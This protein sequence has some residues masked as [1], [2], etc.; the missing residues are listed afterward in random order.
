M[1]R[2]SIYLNFERNAEEAFNF[3][4]TVFGTEFLFPI[5]RFGSVPPMDGQLPVSQEDQNLVMNVQLPI[6]GGAILM[7]NDAPQSMGYKIN[8]GN[9]VLINLEPDTLAETEILFAKLSV[10]GVV[11]S[12]LNKEFWGVYG[13]CIDKFGIQW[14]FNLAE[15]AK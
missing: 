5:D 15:I 9:N 11:K 12:P 14:M 10:D 3:Y 8:K 7:G 1:S 4:K 6:L 2:T 13:E